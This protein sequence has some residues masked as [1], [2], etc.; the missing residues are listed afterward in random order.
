M[1]DLKKLYEYEKK[2]KLKSSLHPIY[3]LS[4]WNY[5]ETVQYQE[6]W[7]E[8]TLNCRALILDSNTGEVIARSFSK[9][10]NWEENKHTPTNNFRIFDKVDG[11][12]GLLFFYRENSL[13]NGRWI[14]TS[15]GSFISEQAIKGKE[16]LDELYPQYVNL[17]KTL[18][19]IFEIIYP[20]N[21]IVVNHGSNRKLVYL[22]S[23]EPNGVEH[24]LLDEM[25]E[26][27]FDTVKEF[28]F[29]EMSLKELKNMNISN[30]EGFVIR[31]DSGERMKVKFEDYLKLHRVTTGLSN[32]KIFQLC[33]TGKSLEE[34]LV[35]IP[36]E[37]NDWFREIHESVETKFNEIKNE[38][39]EYV[40]QNSDKSREDFFSS[41]QEHHYKSLLGALYNNH[42][43]SKIKSKIYSL[44]DF[45]SINIKNRG[46]AAKE[47]PKK[48][49]TMIFLIG[50]SGSGKTTWTNRFMRYRKDCVRV[51]R[52][53]IRISI[54]SLLDDR[55]ISQYYNLPSSELK[56]KEKMVTEI[57]NTIIK[58]GLRD[59]KT[60]IIDNTNLDP[61]FFTEDLKLATEDTIVEY[62]I[63]GQELSDDELFERT[64]NRSQTTVPLKTIKNQTIKFNELL[65]KL[66]QIF[67]KENR[68]LNKINQNTDLERV[69]IFDIDGTLALNLNGISP[70]DMTRLM[71][72]LP[73]NH[74]IEMAQILKK[75]GKKII[76][77]SGRED[78]GKD[79]TIEWM[80][81]YNLEFDELHMRKKGDNRKDFIIKEEFW[82]D[83]CN[84]YYIENMFDDRNQVVEHAR[85]LGFNVCQVA[86][87]NF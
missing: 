30:S 15:K 80:K 3:D 36:D 20:E 40:R 37:F 25:K 55:D 11:S 48:Q 53:T 75:N 34:I 24:L 60:I 4:I 50:R 52:D 74:I 43:E 83:I 17:D 1:F 9:F 64:N 62:K 65:P 84:R 69:V 26:R 6:T 10:F 45:K 44:I 47:K 32:K 35:D 27:G 67:S 61:I 5:S 66:P 86:E 63:L 78:D 22:S 38:C 33:C 28:S 23:F 7:D 56:E 85:K 79:Q 42:E 51:N 14:F 2:G 71:E 54:F 12:L 8:I 76:L 21:R 16:I 31:Y 13:D 49:P 19:Y 81:K 70:Y 57:T 18:S 39:S 29:P 82:R 87:G 59:G 77:C 41:I 72:D 46:F 73:N 58:N 68:L